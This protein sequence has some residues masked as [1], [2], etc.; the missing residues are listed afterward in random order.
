MKTYL[1]KPA[2]VHALLAGAVLLSVKLVLA[3]TG[4]WTL[5]LGNNYT[6]LSFAVILISMFLAGFGERKIRDKFNYWQAFGS[7]VISMSIVVF[8]SLLGDQI[9]YRTIPNLAEMAKEFNLEKL[10]ETFGKTK[11]F[12]ANLQ[13]DIIS[14][15]EKMPAS[16]IY[17]IGSF[18]VSL[19]T[20]CFLNSLWAFLVAAATRKPKDSISTDTFNERF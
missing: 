15:S 5:R 16:Q 9:A 14:E 8:L 13:E 12:G 4:N 1:K 2:I 6:F 18:L 17:S 10:T 3:Y 11:L 7:A 19:I 20:F